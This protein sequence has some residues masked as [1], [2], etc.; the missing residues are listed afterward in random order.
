[1]INDFKP[2]KHLY[3]RGWLGLIPLVGAFVGLG[4]MLLGIFKYRDKKLIFIGIF[5]IVPTV[6]VYGSLFY[7]TSYSSVGSENWEKTSKTFLN[8]LVKD[9][10][11]YHMKN[12]KYPDS[13]EQLRENG[14]L[15]FIN[16]PILA[17]RPGVKNTKFIY[18]KMGEKYTLFSSGLDRVANTKDDIYPTITLSD[19]SKYG[20]IIAK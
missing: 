1:M 20:L 17:R 11:F 15:A 2:A 10:E 12:N 3:G 19:T 5:T 18:K 4:L 9:V 6:L 14:A 13:L 7:L 16:D 8:D